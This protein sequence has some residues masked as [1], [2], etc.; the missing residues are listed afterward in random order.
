MQ[1]ADRAARMHAGVDRD[2]LNENLLPTEHSALFSAYGLRVV[3]RRLAMTQPDRP[4]TG[5]RA[6]AT[7]R[8]ILGDH[9]ALLARARAFIEHL[10]GAVEHPAPESFLGP[11]AVEASGA[12]LGGFV[13]LDGTP[14]LWSGAGVFVTQGLDACSEPTIRPVNTSAGST[15]VVEAGRRRLVL[16]APEGQRFGDGEQALAVLMGQLSGPCF[17]QAIG[18]CDDVRS[19][20]RSDEAL[21]HQLRQEGELPSELV[22]EAP[23]FREVVARVVRLAQCGAP[24][25]LHGPTGV[26]KEMLARVYHRMA[27]D[28]R[29]PSGGGQF[30]AVNCAA[31]PRELA[32][33]QLFGHVKGAFTGADASADGYL[34]SSRGGVLFLDEIGELAP[35]LQAKLLRALDG[36]TRRLGETGPER[37]ITLRVIAATHRDLS[38]EQRLRLDLLHRL[39]TVIEVPPLS[40]RPADILALARRALRRHAVERELAVEGLAPCAAQV[41]IEHPLRGN[42]REVQRLIRE[43]VALRLDPEEAHLLARHL[44][45]SPGIVAEVDLPSRIAAFE[46]RLVAAALARHPSTAAAARSVGDKD[47]TFRKRIARLVRSGWLTEAGAL[48]P[49]PAVTRPSGPWGRALGRRTG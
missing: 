14:L 39:G 19:R 47:Q 44:P 46:A 33:S 24:V 15:I 45:S 31:L 13:D 16:I 1:S 28:R 48:L 5:P 3:L 22:A 32:E 42:A 18:V 17:E 8:R 35:T 41:L 43:A 6:V 11:F 38:D 23:S 4:H 36:H 27:I 20:A 26:G 30:I 7:A 34:E 12:V 9:P 10:D 25:V 2:P 21:L 40:R 37:P 49:G 29:P